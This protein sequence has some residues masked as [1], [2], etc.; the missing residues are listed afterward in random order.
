MVAISGT[1]IRTGMRVIGS[2]GHD[3]GT[4]NEVRANDF[5]LNRRV[6]RDIYVPFS[7]VQNVIGEIV[8]L[9]IPAGQVENMRWPNPPIMGGAGR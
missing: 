9:N 3:T 7:A 4:V 1:Q 2:D 5:L 8:S 6:A